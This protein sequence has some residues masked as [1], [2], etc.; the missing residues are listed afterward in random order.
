MKNSLIVT[1]GLNEDARKKEKEKLFGGLQTKL[2][3]KYSEMED[4]NGWVGDKIEAIEWGKMWYANGESSIECWLENQLI[5]GN[6][7]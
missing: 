3:T 1:Y 4:V 5:I 6:T 2:N 7:F